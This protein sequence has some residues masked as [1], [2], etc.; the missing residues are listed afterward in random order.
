[1]N[2]VDNKFFFPLFLLE[3]LTKLSTNIKFSFSHIKV[4]FVIY[5]ELSTLS[6]ILCEKHLKSNN[7]RNYNRFFPLKNPQ[8]WISKAGFK[9]FKENLWI[10]LN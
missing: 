4:F 10:T 6:T 5:L 2:Y 9:L 1:V 7:E 8:L 3:L